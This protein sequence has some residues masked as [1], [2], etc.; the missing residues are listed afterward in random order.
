MNTEARILVVDDESIW[1]ENFARKIPKD[2]AMQDSAA[3]AQEAAERIR[4]FHYDLVL[5]DL[6]MDL[7]DKSNRDNRPI[8]EY[9]AT[10]PEGTLYFVV[11]STVK[12]EESAEAAFSLGAAGVFYKPLLDWG[13]LIEKVAAAIADAANHRGH[14]IVAARKKLVPDQFVEHKIF[15]TL[16]I[17]ASELYSILDAL[18]RSVAP[19]APHLDRPH[20]AVA[21]GCVV[22]LFWSR[23]KGTAVSAVLAH[24]T[25]KE[26]TALSS[27][28]EWLG[29][30]TRGATLLDTQLHNVR[31]RA[32]E[33]RAIGDGH[34]ELPAIKLTP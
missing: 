2:V 32:F 26:E 16:K 28:A 24:Q 33:E 4:I 11:S 15:G 3:T 17:G 29:F 21:G 6:S 20:C 19:V 31:I 23:R 34:F 25:V 22:A 5:L 10:R 12:I 8:Q 13:V 7:D 9:L 18:S 27:L 14:A 30:P 1:R